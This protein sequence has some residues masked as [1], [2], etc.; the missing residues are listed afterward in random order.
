MRHCICLA[1]L[2]CASNVVLPQARAATAPL[3]TPGPPVS[4]AEYL[5][6]SF[7]APVPGVFARVVNHADGQLVVDDTFWMPRVTSMDPSQYLGALSLLWPNNDSLLLRFQP[8]IDAGLASVEISF[9]T[10]VGNSRPVTVTGAGGYSRTYDANAIP[11][12]SA[13][14]LALVACCLMRRWRR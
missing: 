8:E 13:V 5:E 9:G 12:P 1:A 11:E 3:V 6:V 10:R 14:A 7:L 2:V 4:T